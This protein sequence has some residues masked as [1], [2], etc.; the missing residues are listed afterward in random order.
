MLLGSEPI[1][2][3]READVPLRHA[4]CIVTG[5]AKIDAVPDA[6]ELRMMI[7]LLGM[8]CDARQETEGLAEVLEG[9]ATAQRLAALLHRPSIGNVHAAPPLK[10]RDCR[11][12]WA[13]KESSMATQV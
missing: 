4:A 5:E 11:S 2:R 7:D 12:S 6:R 8:K 13:A 1:D 10:C 9:E 3:F